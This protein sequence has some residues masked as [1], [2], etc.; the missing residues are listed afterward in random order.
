MKPGD[1]VTRAEAE[2]FLRHDLLRFQAGVTKLVHVSLSQGQYDAL[3]SFCY[4]IGEGDVPQVHPPQVAQP[5]ALRRGGSPVRR[6]GSRWWQEAPRSRSQ[7]CR[8]S[9][10]VQ[11]RRR[12]GRRTADRS[13]HE[14]RDD[15]AEEPDELEDR[16]RCWRRCSGR[17]WRSGRSGQRH[18]R[19][20]VVAPGHVALDAG[21]GENCTTIINGDISQSDIPGKSGLAVL[22]EIVH[23]REIEGVE[24]IEFTL[25]DIVRSNLCAAFVRAFHERGL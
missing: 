21:F 4:N 13:E 3:V 20:A 16:G 1:K 8:R 9:R 24:I 14:D 25:D 5:E 22:I 11:V 17:W 2:S 18:G 10:S 19:E 7:A 23:D 12:P 6:M 15:R